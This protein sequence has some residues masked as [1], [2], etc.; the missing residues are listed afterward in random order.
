MGQPEVGAHNFENN[1][2]VPNPD[3]RRDASV[4]LEMMVQNVKF[5]RSLMEIEPWKS[6]IALEIDPHPNYISD[7]IRSQSI[8]LLMQCH[9]SIINTP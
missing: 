2:G 9:S 5:I 7:K 4:D 1:F 8:Y 6:A 3:S